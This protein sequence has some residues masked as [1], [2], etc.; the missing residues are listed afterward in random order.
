MILCGGKGWI[1]LRTCSRC[2]DKKPATAEYFYR[3]KTSK[4]GL[5]KG[6]KACVS[7]YAKKYIDM[8][9]VRNRVY[10]YNRAWKKRQ[11][12]KVV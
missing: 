8:Q 7:K 3:D 12:K 5:V 2:G 10:A 6:C 4:D 9:G 11:T 1:N